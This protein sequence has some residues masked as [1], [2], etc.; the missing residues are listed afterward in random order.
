MT[1]NTNKSTDLALRGCNV[2]TVLGRLDFQMK[3]L[4]QAHFSEVCDD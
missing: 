2:L 3:N 1:I 4:S